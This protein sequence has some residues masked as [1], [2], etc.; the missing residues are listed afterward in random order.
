METK[1]SVT[2]DL[3]YL[4]YQNKLKIHQ[5]SKIQQVRKIIPGLV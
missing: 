2:I 5:N 1:V 3:I 4:L